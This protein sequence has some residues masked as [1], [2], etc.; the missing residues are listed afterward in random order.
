M[1]RL[2][3]LFIALPVILAATI[4]TSVVTIVGGLFNAHIFGYYPGKLWS[5]VLCRVLLPA[6]YW[7]S[8]F[9]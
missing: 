9:T 1:Y 2:Y 3:Q 4:L 5:K 7:S 6:P 8:F